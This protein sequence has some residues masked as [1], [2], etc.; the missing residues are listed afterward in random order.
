M[1]HEK[2]CALK[3][4]VRQGTFRSSVYT[5]DFKHTAGSER[6]VQNYHEDQGKDRGLLIPVWIKSPPCF[7]YACHGLRSTM[8]WIHRFCPDYHNRSRARDRQY[9]RC[10]V[11]APKLPFLRTHVHRHS[12]IPVIKLCRNRKEIARCQSHCLHLLQNAV[13]IWRSAPILA[14]EMI[15]L[16]MVPRNFLIPIACLTCAIAQ[17]PAD[18]V[19]GKYKKCMNWRC[20]PALRFRYV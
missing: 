11:L 13:S 14:V 15:L 19:T 18:H 6:Q 17:A 12:C 16:V 10:P 4:T 7:S 3:F 2:E 1:V 8:C 5:V 9:L 20:Y